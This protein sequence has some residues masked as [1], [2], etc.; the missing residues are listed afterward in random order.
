MSESKR[1]LLVQRMSRKFIVIARN[2]EFPHLSPHDG[3]MT[4]NELRTCLAENYGC[5]SAE[6]ESL[7]I[8][9]NRNPEAGQTT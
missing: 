7:I 2:P 4:E 1:Q 3:Q 9:A 6:I 5:S 8:E